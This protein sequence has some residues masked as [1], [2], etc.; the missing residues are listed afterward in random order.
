MPFSAILPLRA[1]DSAAFKMILSKVRLSA[2][3]NNFSIQQW[4]TQELLIIC[5][6]T[7]FSVNVFLILFTGIMIALISSSTILFFLSVF[8]SVLKI[9]AS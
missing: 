6:I 9:K 4:G 5:V 1:N 7:V 2:L 3:L 8:Y